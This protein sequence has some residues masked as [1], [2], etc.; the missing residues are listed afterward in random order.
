M[1]KPVKIAPVELDAPIETHT[2]GLEQI[3]VSRR[4]IHK[5]LP[6][7]PSKEI[8]LKSIDVARWAPNH[9]LTEPWR[10]YLIGNETKEAIAHLNARIVAERKGPEV[11][12]AKL[13]QWLAV[14]S[15]VVATYK[16]AG[17]PCREKEDYAST[18]CAIHN[19]SLYLWSEGIGMKWSTSKS[20]QSPEFLD[21]LAIDAAREEVVGLLWCGYPADVPEKTRKPVGS[22]VRE[23][24]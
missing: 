23:L 24:P 3:I 5:F 13:A 11:A 1:D 4:T 18:C 10:F 17:D 19:M 12:K 7:V 6:A 21:L 9:K 14:P 15:M 2:A 16:K 8:F 20:T 22:I